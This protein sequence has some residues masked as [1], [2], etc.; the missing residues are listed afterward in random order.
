M[1][2][3]TWNLD[4]LQDSS[5]PPFS[6]FQAALAARGLMIDYSF[7]EGVVK[8]TLEIEKDW[9]ADNV[10]GNTAGENASSPVPQKRG[11]PTCVPANDI[12]LARVRHMRFMNIP[13]SEIAKEIGVSKRT[14][15]RQWKKVM[16]NHPDDDTPFSK[17]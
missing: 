6:T 2:K 12:T 1:M 5:N 15:Y 10:Q 14:F 7:K 4:G 9:A 3:C 11:R 13:V 16:E 17:W 8:L